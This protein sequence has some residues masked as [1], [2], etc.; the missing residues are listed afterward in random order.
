MLKL[1]VGP[2]SGLGVLPE[3]VKSYCKIS[4]DCLF[5]CT[6]SQDFL[7]IFVFKTNL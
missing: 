3:N 1:E 4:L 6:V 7:F 5:K 2:Y